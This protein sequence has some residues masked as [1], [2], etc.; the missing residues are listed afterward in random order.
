M[1]T[2]IPIILT[3]AGILIILA[4]FLQERRRKGEF[5]ALGLGLAVVAT[6]L[7]LSITAP[8]RPVSDLPVVRTTTVQLAPSAAVP[9]APSPAGS[10]AVPG[11]VALATAS[12]GQA[13]SIPA[14]TPS[15]TPST[16]PTVWPS[17]T[18]AP[19]AQAA[20][21]GTAD[22]ATAAPITQAVATATATRPARRRAT[23]SPSPTG[24][25]A[26]LPGVSLAL[27]AASVGRTT[28]AVAN[29][30]Y[31]ELV[32][33]KQKLRSGR[34]EAGLTYQDGSSAV[35]TARF[36]L[37]DDAHAPALH[38]TTIYTGSDGIQI[39]ERIS[40][41]AHTWER[42]VGS[43]WIAL[44][45]TESVS[46]LIQALLPSAP[47]RQ[48]IVNSGSQEVG[49]LYWYDPEQLASMTVELHLATGMPFSFRKWTEVTNLSVAYSDWNKAV[50]IKP[51]PDL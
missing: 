17:P 23:L 41:G 14:P 50:E 34:L 40:I 6:M 46:E 44:P 10:T 45:T 20:M 49:L 8:A 36:H 29:D 11:D 26:A 43:A 5:L 24:T 25:G 22:S 30:L 16:S 47:S 15:T 21:S 27:T 38:R 4:F 33:I 19:V 2:M 37:G 31:Q 1:V 9:P 12:P 32:A 42:K 39:Y 28:T 7:V 13:N 3:V 48:A 35:I 51:P 18:A